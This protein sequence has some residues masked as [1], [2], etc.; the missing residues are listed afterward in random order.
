MRAKDPGVD[1][2]MLVLSRGSISQRI[3]SLTAMTRLMIVEAQHAWART[4]L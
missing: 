3:F 1:P 4:Q 2:M